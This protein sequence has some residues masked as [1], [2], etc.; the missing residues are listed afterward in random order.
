MATLPTNHGHHHAMKTENKIS[1]IVTGSGFID[2]VCELTGVMFRRLT[3]YGSVSTRALI[4]TFVDYQL[5]SYQIG[6][7][8]LITDRTE[9]DDM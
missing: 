7:L 2:C 3:V 6:N 1:V 5:P 8:L 4:S 9:E